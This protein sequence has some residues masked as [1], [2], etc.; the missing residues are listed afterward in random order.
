MERA[1]AASAGCGREAA[2]SGCVQASIR[3][4]QIYDR[5][6]PVD[7]GAV[8]LVNRKSGKVM[9]VNGASS[10]DGASVIQRPWTGGTSQQWKL[11]PNADGSYRLAN[12]RSGKVLDSPSSSAQ[13]AGLDRLTGNGSAGQSWKLV[14]SATNGYYQ[15]VNVGTGWCADVADASTADG[16]EIIQWPATGGSDQDWQVV[17]L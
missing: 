15:L 8:K 12:V 10:A 13:G 1:E 9:D 7:A 17:M 14:P 3:G 16:I 2:D 11:L 4:L 6:I 5:P